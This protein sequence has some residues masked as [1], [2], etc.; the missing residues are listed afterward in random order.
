MEV[1]M[2]KRCRLL[3]LE[4]D[5]QLTSAS[6]HEQTF[7]L[8]VCHTGGFLRQ[9]LCIPQTSISE[10]ASMAR[11]IPRSSCQPSDWSGPP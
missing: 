10:K 3:H 7:A 4:E 2:G 6:C 5:V 8:A 11:P 9:V 1:R